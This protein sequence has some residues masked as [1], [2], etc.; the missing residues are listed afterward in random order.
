M[1][2]TVRSPGGEMHPVGKM[3]VVPPW[4]NFGKERFVSRHFSIKT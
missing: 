4:E 1:Y 3:E 2:G